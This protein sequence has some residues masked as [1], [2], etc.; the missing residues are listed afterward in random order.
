MKNKMTVCKVCNKEIATSAKVCPY[1]GAK[2]KKKKALIIGIVI[3][4]ILI[5]A[6]AGGTAGSSES[7]GTE[8]YKI[9]EA[10]AT[11]KYELTVTKVE[12]KTVVGDELFN[13]TPVE[14]AVYVAVQY[15]YKNTSKEP[16][17][18][19]DR[20]SVKLTSPDGVIYDFDLGATTYYMSQFDIDEKT[21]SDLNPGLSANSANVFEVAKTELEKDGWFINVDGKKVE[22]TF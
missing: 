19:W 4:V 9:G 7:E 12:K 6:M 18:I 1:C 11:D 10:V 13:S 14:G 2:Q 17:T 3:I 16:L 21:V 8:F 20:P 22:L 5:I 15:G